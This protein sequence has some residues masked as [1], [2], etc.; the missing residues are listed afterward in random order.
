[1]RQAG[2]FSGWLNYTW[3]RVEDRLPEGYRARRWDQRHAANLGL[4]WSPDPWTVTLAYAYHSGW[5]MTAAPENAAQSAESLRQGT[6]RRLH[7]YA[8]LDLRLTRAFALPHGTLDVFA[9]LTNAL[10]RSNPCC[11]EYTVDATQDDPSYRGRVRS[12]LPR[13]PSIG[14]LWRY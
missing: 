5:P 3:S 9:E 2:A 7:D 14:V 6:T 1:M 8:S 11:I 13:V 4:T 10:A 12:W